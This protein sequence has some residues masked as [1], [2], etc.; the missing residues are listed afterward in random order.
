MR[1]HLCGSRGGSGERDNKKQA[2]H[3]QD[4]STTGRCPRPGCPRGGRDYCRR[5]WFC[6]DG[7]NEGREHAEAQLS[8]VP[9]Q[10][11]GQCAVECVVLRVEVM[12]R[13]TGNFLEHLRVA[14]KV[15]ELCQPLATSSGALRLRRGQCLPFRSQAGQELVPGLRTAPVQHKAAVAEIEG[16]GRS[17]GDLENPGVQGRA[18]AGSYAAP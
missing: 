16:C 10:L 4:G 3:A 12:Q 17:K 14:A 18:Y 2:A 9:V 8:C 11:L 15:P 7:L 6:E 13:V 5:L 1:S